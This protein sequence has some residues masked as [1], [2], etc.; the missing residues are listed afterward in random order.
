MTLSF[1]RLVLPLSALLSVPFAPAAAQSMNE[2]A[3][4]LSEHPSLA[5][6]RLEAGAQADRAQA[7]GALP[8]PDV[9]LGVANLPVADPAFDRFLPT[10]KAVGVRQALPDG[11]TRRARTA[12]ALA[13]ASTLDLRLE[14]ER[15]RLMAELVALLAEREAVAVRRNVLRRQDEAYAEL[16]EAVESE[17]A[18]G[19]A[20]AFRLGAVDAER[21]A[22]GSARAALDAETARI[23]AALVNLVGLIPEGTTAPNMELPVW[24]GAASDFYDVALAARG[25]ERAEAGVDL[26]RGAYRPD[27]S[28]GLT[29]QQREA[30]GDAALA[31]FPGDDWVTAQVTFSV[32]LYAGRSQAPRLRAARAEK[33]AAEARLQA[34]ARRTRARFETG[35]AEARAAEASADAIAAQIGALGE[36]IAA[37]RTAYEAGYGDYS[38]VLDGEVTRLGLTAALASERARRT[39]AAARARSLLLSEEDR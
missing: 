19:Q 35:I 24:S 14:A 12:Q 4:R 33:A 32:P 21:A 34:A 23:E 17:V 16:A 15:A 13:E 38:A 18:G 9:T 31:G 30:S 2:L 8:D 26:A 27:W 11:L 29:Y 22:L 1:R 10:H 25:I 37:S 39:A 28:V 6:I 7:A 5:A 20:V 3:A 36:R